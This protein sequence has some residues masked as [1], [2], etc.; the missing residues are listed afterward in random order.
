MQFVLSSRF[1]ALDCPLKNYSEVR[2]GE[3]MSQTDELR[4]AVRRVIEQN[5][6]VG[7]RPGRFVQ[8]TEDGTASNIVEVCEHLLTNPETLEH[9]EAAV[10]AYAGLLTLEEEV[11]RHAEGFG[12]SEKAR[13]SA[14]ER[15]DWFL[16]I[17]PKARS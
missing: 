2:R 14:R 7:Y 15:L 3:L 13:M 16:Q 8:A 5:I 1:G 17:S 11:V 4:K 10:R 6:T 9:I 12:L